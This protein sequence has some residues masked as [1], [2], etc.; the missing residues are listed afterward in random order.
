MSIILLQFR[1]ISGIAGYGWLQKSGDQ[2]SHCG[3]AKKFVKLIK[4]MDIK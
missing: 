2:L 3:F 4:E 1:I